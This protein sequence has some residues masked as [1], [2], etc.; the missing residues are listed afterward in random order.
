MDYARIEAEEALVQSAV[1]LAEFQ[2]THIA[3]YLTMLFAYIVVAYAAGVKLT[4]FQIILTN[5]LFVTVCLYEVLV[6][7]AIGLGASQALAKISQFTGD[8]YTQAPGTETVWPH[9]IMWSTGII[10]ALL[11]MWSVRRKKS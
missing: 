8:E 3:I 1:A 9:A 10:A 6:I 11:F 4:R 2:A 7:A 5:I